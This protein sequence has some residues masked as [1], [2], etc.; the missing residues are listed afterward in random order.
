MSRPATIGDRLRETGNLLPA[1]AITAYARP[2]DE[3]RVRAAGFQRHVAKPFD[4]EELVRAVGE[5]KG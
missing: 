2:E 5:L 3:A 4:P 1:L